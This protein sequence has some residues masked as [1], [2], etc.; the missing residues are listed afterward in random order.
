MSDFCWTCIGE[1]PNTGSCR[2]AE[3]VAE[4][5]ELELKSLNL[6]SFAE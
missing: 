5:E 6:D 1:L 3:M 2:Y 4:E